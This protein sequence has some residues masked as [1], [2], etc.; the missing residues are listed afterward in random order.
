MKDI[1]R[2]MLNTTTKKKILIAGEGDIGK[3]IKSKLQYDYSIITVSRSS[4]D[5][6][7]DLS[8]QN[9]VK[10]L[11]E[12][13]GVVYSVIC[14]V[15]GPQKNDCIDNLEFDFFTTFQNNLFAPINLT[16]YYFEK[17]KK[18]KEGCF[19]YMSSNLTSCIRTPKNYLAY[20]LA[21]S[22]LEKMTDILSTN[23]ANTN[24]RFNCIKLG[25]VRTNKYRESMN[26]IDMI[27]K[28]GS[29]SGFVEEKQ[30][31]EM[32]KFILNN[33]SITGLTVRLDNGNHH[34]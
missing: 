32:I 7:G 20:T 5:Y 9:F 10:N 27:K 22:S 23:E 1:C 11:A 6:I 17:M 29:L 3:Y 18:E 15:G 25:F 26:N 34:I 2:N 33:K 16:R 12:K 4:G 13:T 19:I 8:D 24:I 28:T 30:V 21:K 31:Y 14:C